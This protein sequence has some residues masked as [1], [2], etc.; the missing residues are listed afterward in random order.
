MWEL[1]SRGPRKEKLKS[2]DLASEMGNKG[3]DIKIYPVKV[4]SL[5]SVTA[6]TTTQ[7]RNLGINGV[8]AL[9][10]ATKEPSE[11]SA[12]WLWFK[13]IKILIWKK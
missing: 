1:Y 7:L 13:K 6:S 9:R 5:I 12:Q 3:W 2:T 4:G 10:Q 11:F 8:G